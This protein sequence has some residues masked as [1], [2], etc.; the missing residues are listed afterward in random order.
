MTT[1]QCQPYTQQH[2]CMIVINSSKVKQLNLAKSMYVPKH[3]SVLSIFFFKLCFSLIESDRF[4]INNANGM[5]GQHKR[6]LSYFVI[7]AITSTHAYRNNILNKNLEFT[8]AHRGVFIKVFFIPE[9]FICLHSTRIIIY[10][11]L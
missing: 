2:D 11:L 6:H 9:T 10:L 3:F 4:T 8:S 1:N 7:T 5:C